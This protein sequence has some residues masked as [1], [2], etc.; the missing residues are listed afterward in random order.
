MKLE[1]SAAIV[2]GLWGTAALVEAAPLPVDAGTMMEDQLEKNA[3]LEGLPEG[4]A[5]VALPEDDRPQLDIPGEVKIQVNGFKISGQDIYSEEAL[6]KAAGLSEY[7]GKMCSFQDLQA[8]ADRLSGYLRQHGYLMARAYL[9]VQK[10]TNGVVEY[11]ILVGKIDTIT[12]KN[13]ADIH[14]SALQRQV[15]FLKAGDYLTREKLERAVWLLSDLAGANAKASLE[16]GKTQGTVAIVFDMQ[17][18]RGKQGLLSVDN[19]G[20]RYTGYNEYGLDYNFLNPTRNGDQLALGIRFT[21]EKLQNYGARYAL[22]LVRDGLKLSL[23]YNT[24]F[25]H[26]GDTYKNAEAYGTARTGDIGFDYAILRSQYSNLYAGLHYEYSELKDEIR[27]AGWSVPKHSHGLVMSVA[28]DRIWAAGSYNWRLD[29]KWGRLSFDSETGRQQDRLA[30][31]GRSF[32]KLRGYFQQQW[33]LNPRLSAYASLRGQWA[34]CN[35]DSS[36]HFSLGGINGVRAYPTSEASGDMGY[37]VRG[38]LRWHVPLPY[39]QQLQ[40][41]GFVDHGGVWIDKDPA[42]N[43]ENKRFLQGAGLG[44]AWYGSRDFFIRADYAWTIGAQRSLSDAGHSK[45][46]LWLRAGMYF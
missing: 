5:Q 31:T 6:L 7:T 18:Y 14:E 46:R 37:L 22:P 23:G 8:G 25:Y 26:L 16:T 10:I 39:E 30:H 12:F 19:Y 44:L 17:P 45:G 28:G 41:I 15:G 34:S 4:H 29:Y 11:V 32:H 1:V 24:L 21:G 35:L 38:E 43:G 3:T 20:N 36:E 27:A 2:W 40:V 9:P 13:E 33:Y 42:G